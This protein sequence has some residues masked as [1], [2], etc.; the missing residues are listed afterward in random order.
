MLG[1]GPVSASATPAGRNASNEVKKRKDV[2]SLPI[3][4]ALFER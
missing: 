4:S 3:I 2:A 1:F